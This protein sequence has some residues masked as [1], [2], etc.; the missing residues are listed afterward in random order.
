MTDAV[1]AALVARQ[2]RA[3][4]IGDAWVFPALR[5]PGSPCPRATFN[6]WWV[7]GAALAK[8]PDSPGLGYHSL[9]RQFA[10]ELKGTPLPDLAALGGW[11]SAQTILTCYQRPDEATQR[12]ALE[13][14]KVLKASGLA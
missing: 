10:T 4:A 13:R 8:L 1:H 14:R 3:A 7:R 5:R 2:R 12:A 6:K 9:R 11:K